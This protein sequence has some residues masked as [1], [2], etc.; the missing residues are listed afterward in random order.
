M[1]FIKRTKVDSK[2]ETS[3]KASTKAA[4]VPTAVDRTPAL[5]KETK[6]AEA[7][8]ESSTSSTVANSSRQSEITPEQIHDTDMVVRLSEGAS[9][10]KHDNNDILASS[11]EFV[12]PPLKRSYSSLK[13]DETQVIITGLALANLASISDKKTDRA[14]V[15]E[16]LTGSSDKKSLSEILTSTFDMKLEASFDITDNS[17]SLH[18][19]RLQGF[20]ATNDDSVVLSYHLKKPASEWVHELDVTTLEW[21]VK[22]EPT[23]SD[24]IMNQFYAFVCSD[25]Q[26]K[27]ST[28]GTFYRNF[29]ASL[30]TIEEHILPLMSADQKPRTLY[31][32][33]DSIG[34]GV[35]TLAACY[36]SLELAWDA[37]PHSLI[38]VTAG[39][40]RSCTISM[41]AY[42]DECL[43]KTENKI[44]LYRV[45]HETDL[46]PTMPSSAY[47]FQHISQPIEIQDDGTILKTD[48]DL[49]TG[50]LC[51]DL[52]PVPDVPGTKEKTLQSHTSIAYLGSFLKHADVSSF[53]EIMKKRKDDKARSMDDKEMNANKKKTITMTK[54]PSIERSSSWW[55]RS[56]SSG[57]SR[58]GPI[59]ALKMAFSG[60][61]DDSERTTK[62]EAKA[63]NSKSKASAPLPPKS[64][65]DGKKITTKK[66]S[67]GLK[68]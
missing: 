4:V 65:P 5:N 61:Q 13:E 36:F 14:K 6:P 46:V 68:A 57:A 32:V 45:I 8:C 29:M 39:G 11:N 9:D 30:P 19:V 18:S 42:M 2:A 44:R 60:A 40:P 16:Q 63:S 23:F 53:S 26:Y 62:T 66:A 50:I 58:K 43:K 41:K 51:L 12:V 64:K 59:G 37:I 48:A 47:G 55:K 31:V 56:R 38:N 52:D 27:P 21:D 24:T 20:V 28:H 35:A 33:G 15:I 10:K 1:G 17:M 22:K 34:A 67:T 49:D 54:A 3:V 25:S 7:R